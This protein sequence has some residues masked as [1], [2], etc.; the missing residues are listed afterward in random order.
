MDI[1]TLRSIAAAKGASTETQKMKKKDL[2]K[3]LQVQHKGVQN[4]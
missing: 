3:Y 4:K 2:V 1:A